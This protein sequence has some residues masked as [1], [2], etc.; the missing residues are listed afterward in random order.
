MNFNSKEDLK[1]YKVYVHVNKIN[2]KPYVGV[3]KQATKRRWQNGKGYSTQKKF[4]NAIKKYGWSN[5]IHVTIESELTH[6]EACELEQ[7]YI[8]QYNSIKNGY[9]TTVG[10]DGCKG[11]GKKVYQYTLDMKLVNVFNSKTQLKELLKIKSVTTIDNWCKADKPQNGYYWKCEEDVPVDEKV[12]MELNKIDLNYLKF[13]PYGEQNRKRTVEK[14]DRQRE[15]CFKK[16]NQYKLDGTYIKT[17]DSI[18]EAKDYYNNTSI[19]VALKKKGNTASGYQWRYDDG[20]HNNIESTTIRRERKV[21]QMD[22]DGK[23]IN[24][25]NSLKEAQNT[26]GINFKMIW[27]VCNGVG[28][29]TGGYKW[30]YAQ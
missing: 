23:T 3:T 8:E 5:F 20:N 6:D 17:W 15:A 1:E 26:T 21:L 7:Y 27:K 4:Y 28:Q 9:N 12:D 19:Q 22:L 25:Y 2:G 16:I 11:T 13:N 30:A 24:M 18:I 14:I 29:S 10:G